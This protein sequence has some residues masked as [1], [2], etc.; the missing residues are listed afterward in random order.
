MVFLS[1]N[2]ISRYQ[3]QHTACKPSLESPL[4]F[5]TLDYKYG[6]AIIELIAQTAFNRKL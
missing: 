5:H 3:Q 4:D 2:P 1:T 6:K